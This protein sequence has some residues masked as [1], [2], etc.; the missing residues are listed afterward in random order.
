MWI[1][2]S[3][4]LGNPGAA[5]LQYRNNTSWGT[6]DFQLWARDNGIFWDVPTG[7]SNQITVTN[8]YSAGNWTHIAITR[9]SG[10]IRAYINGVFKAS[11]SDSTTF[12]GNG[13]T[14][15]IANIYDGSNYYFNGYISNFRL[16]KGT[17]IYNSAFT[18][19][20]SPLVAVANTQLL[21]CQSNRIVDNSTNRTTLSTV[22]SPPVYS[23]SPFGPVTVTPYYSNYFDGSGDYLTLASNPAFSFGTGDF[24]VEAWIYLTSLAT[25]KDVIDTRS[26]DSLSS[27]VFNIQAAG[28]LDFIYG[29]SRLTSAATIS[30]N[31]WTHVAVSRSG[32]TIRLFI[33]G[34]VDT[35]TA[36]YASADRKSTRLN[37]SH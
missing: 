1:N 3:E 23:F 33:N 26:V 18:P 4:S 6:G 34:T 15:R 17:I 20:T 19:P 13:G 27:Y 10:T 30:L 8:A 16:V 11:V 7:G 2:P 35:N 28:T 32:S 29:A 21:T 36:T 31:T 14:K 9:Q 22:S 12:N 5:L 37:S 24:T 25:P